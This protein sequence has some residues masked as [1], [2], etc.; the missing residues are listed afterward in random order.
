VI[1]APT[2]PENTARRFTLNGLDSPSPPPI[3]P[4]PP[5]PI[6]LVLKKFFLTV[7]RRPPTYVAARDGEIED[8]AAGYLMPRSWLTLKHNF[9]R[10][11]FTFVSMTIDYLLML[12][13]MTFN[14][15]FFLAAIFGI[16]LGTLFF[17]HTM[18][19]MRT[20]KEA[21]SDACRNDGYPG[22]QLVIPNPEVGAQIGSCGAMFIPPKGNEPLPPHENLF[23]PYMDNSCCTVV[24]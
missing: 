17:G 12:I 3:P 18:I 24:P 8:Y 16:S 21:V 22:A 23:S 15:G 9:L 10:S 11:C 1:L 4:P 19:P 20:K 14:I 6:L 7:S 2:P 5:P 13:A